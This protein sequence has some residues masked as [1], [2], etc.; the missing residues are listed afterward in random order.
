[1]RNSFLQPALA[2]LLAGAASAQTNGIDPRSTLHITFP[3]DSPVTVLSADWGESNASARGGA[4]LLD[5]HTSLMLRNS[6]NRKIRG[7]TLI[8]MAQEVTPG[9]KAS[10]SAPSL[11]VA[12]GE[13]FPI[14]IDLRLLRPLHVGNGPL[15][16]V[17]LDGLLFDDLSFF[18]P[19]KLNSRRSMTVWELEA[20][21][22]RRYFKNVLER[23]G[24]ESLKSEML[25]SLDRQ[26]ARAKM[27]ARVAVAGRATNVSSD[28]QVQLAF[29][30]PPRGP[31][32]PLEGSV[33]IDGNEAR[34]PRV[35]IRNRSD[36]QVEAMEI[37]WLIKDT[38][39]REFVTGAIPLDVSIFP[40]QTAN[41]VQDVAFKFSQPGGQALQIETVSGYIS[42]V[43]FADGQMWVP[44]RS[45]KMLTPSPEEQRLAEMYRKRGLQAVIEEL[46]RF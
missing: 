8:V 28:R 10:V 33:R 31:I 12:P 14:R 16:E 37:G 3:E 34:S 38:R 11:N 2:V 23:A 26:A 30:D 20:R 13:T 24:N 4:M 35:S 45:T 25:A 19:N 39:G 5:L 27:D 36:R 17:G 32:E 6:G 21:R 15:V 44:E 18:G 43:E 40:R 41:V 29:V 22:D 9:G 1:M 42:S 46:K 7:V